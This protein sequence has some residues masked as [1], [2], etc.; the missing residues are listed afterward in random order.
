MAAMWMSPWVWS[1]A[2]LQ[3]LA[4]GRLINLE[5]VGRTI[6]LVCCDTAS[7]CVSRVP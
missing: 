7:H 6:D 1:W 5:H 4:V 3:A 2:E